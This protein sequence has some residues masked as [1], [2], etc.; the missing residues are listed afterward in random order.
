[1]SKLVTSEIFIKRA[2]EKHYDK[3]DYSKV[4]YIKQNEK[5]ILICPIHGEFLMEPRNHLRSNSGCDK[6]KSN[7][8]ATN[9]TF[10]EKAKLIHGNKYDYSLI[11]YRNKN[12]EL[13]INCP[14]HGEFKQKARYIIG[15]SGCQKC[16]WESI[17][18]FQRLSCEEFIQRAKLVHKN[19]YNYSLVNYKKFTVKVK[20][21]CSEHGIFEQRP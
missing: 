13:I 12:S 18:N 17:G 21:I 11:N 8:T 1:M 4:N 3:F 19:K 2:K 20:I 9:E 10:I 7:L 15:G 14:T 5:V 6:C 16:S